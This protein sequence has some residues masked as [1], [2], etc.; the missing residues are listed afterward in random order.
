MRT[1]QIPLGAVYSRRPVGAVP[2]ISICYSSV[3]YPPQYAFGV[4]PSDMTW[5]RTSAEVTSCKFLVIHA[6]C[7][8]ASGES[9]MFEAEVSCSGLVC[10]GWDMATVEAIRRV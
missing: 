4:L 9:W 10:S 1:I 7:F 8:S 3:K 2:G 6:Y 5:R